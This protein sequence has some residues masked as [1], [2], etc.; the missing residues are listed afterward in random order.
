MAY[1]A[2][3]EN[4]LVTNVIIAEQEFIDTLP[5]A[6]QWVETCFAAS[7]GVIYDEQGVPT[8]QPVFRKNYASIGF[9]YDPVADVFIPP[10]PYSSWTLNTDTYL[11]EPPVPRPQGVDAVWDEAAQT[12]ITYE[13]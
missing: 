13:R 2:K 12:W 6:T 9:S 5:D 10:R 3:V 11:W 4:S 1:F 8:M 7:G